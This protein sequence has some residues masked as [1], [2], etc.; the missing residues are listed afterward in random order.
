MIEI[1]SMWRLPSSYAELSQHDVHIWYASLNQP[2]ASFERLAL[3][4]SPDEQARAKRFYFEKDRIRYANGRGILRSILAYYL[5]IEPQYVQLC[6]GDYGKPYLER[7]SAEMALDFNLSHSNDLAL[8]AITRGKSVG[9]DLE[10][11]R[12]VADIDQVVKKFFAAREQVA[13]Y[14]LHPHER[15]EA[16][17]KVWTRKEA[18]LK[19]IG[20]GLSEPLYYV[21]VSVSPQGQPG[22]SNVVGNSQ[23]ASR[24]F[25]QDMASP[26]GYVATL[27]VEEKAYQLTYLQQQY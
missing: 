19:A 18:Y 11:I 5:N 1:D 25:L 8:Y 24:W 26:P 6:Y 4:L 3:L 23:A 21:E 15:R 12:E 2:L 13:F 9:I 7:H 17:F 14:N 20:V 27:A 22:L 10:H 16:F